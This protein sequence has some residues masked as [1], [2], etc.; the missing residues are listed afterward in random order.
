M[1]FS[2]AFCS[3]IPYLERVP[4]KTAS[5]EIQAPKKAFNK[6]TLLSQHFFSLSAL[7]RFAAY[8]ARRT[9]FQYPSLGLK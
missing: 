6:R 3:G 4:S 7:P 8:Y 2:D 5:R 9:I 1:C